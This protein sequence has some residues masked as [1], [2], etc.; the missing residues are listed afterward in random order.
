MKLLI[1]VFIILSFSLRCQ[2]ATS[3]INL[4]SINYSLIESEFLTRLNALRTD[5]KL[6]TLGTDNILKKAAADQAGYQEEKHF[7]THEQTVKGK[8]KPQNRVFYY[9]GTHDL[10]GEN[11]IKIPLKLPFKTKYKNTPIEVK[12]YADAG[13]ALFMGWKNSPGHYKN[14][15]NP[16]YDVSGL[17]F[18]FDKD[19]SYL[20]CAQVFGAKPFQFGVEYLSPPDAYGV[21]ESKPSVCDVFNSGEA[22]RAMRSLQLVYSGD[23]IFLR[24]EEAD[25]LR[26]FFNKPND[27]IYF[28]IVQRKQFVCDKNN[29]LHGSAVFDGKM[30]QPIPFSEI[31]KRSR[32]KD[33]KNLYASVCRT[34]KQLSAHKTDQLSYGFIKNG[35]SCEYIYPIDIPAENMQ[36]LDLYPKWIYMQNLEVKPDSFE[37]TLSFTIPFERGEVQL[38]EQKKKQLSEKLE[39]YQPFIKKVNLQTFSSIEGSTTGNIKIQELRSANIAAIL[40]TYHID[41]LTFK[42]QTAENWDDFFALIE[43]TEVGYLKS[44]SKDKIK[45]KLKSK[46]LLDSL[47][48]LLR[49]NRTALLTLDIK[50]VVN[51]ESNPYLILAAYKKS[52]EQGDSLKAFTNQNKLLEYVTKYQ[53]ES[54]DLLPVTIPLTRKFL[55]HIANYLAVTVKDNEL[56]YSRFATDI[57][58]QASKIDENYLPVKFNLCIINLKYL[59]EFNDTLIPIIELEKKMNDCFKLGTYED[60]IIVNHMWLDYSILSLYKNWSRHLYQ[61][62]DKH[63]A[64]VKKYY[65]GSH[66][67]EAEA[68]KLGLLF[69]LYSRADWTCDLL[70]PYTRT[71]TKNEDILFLFIQTYGSF[72]SGIIQ[73]VEWEKYLKRAKKMNPSRFNKWVDEDN[74]QLLR[75]PV[76]KKVFCSST[77]G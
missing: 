21:L 22:K 5:Q 53:F 59:H 38:S 7:L 68:I 72:K 42:T 37:G 29:L 58:L 75:D 34:P 48:Y 27:A 3:E 57:A 66:I 71:K 50:A 33:G 63:L 47:D 13:E 61:N 65:P 1:S 69:N 39:I 45:E 32:I 19:S 43:N 28:D 49:V 36:M 52:I 26:R 77:E 11:C 35:Y 54:T 30:L 31:F 25:L 70:L 73:P 18:A 74:F 2:T 20:Y 16:D 4:S 64:G 46:L 15:I 51:N 67:S 76:V 55:P 10:V 6:N 44:F 14:M 24:S 40:K 60:S 12:T 56:F 17:G 9:Y 8:E 41:S 62:I 23:S